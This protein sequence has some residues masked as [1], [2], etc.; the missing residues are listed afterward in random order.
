MQTRLQPEVRKE[1]I[2][3]AALRVFAEKGFAEASNRDIAKAAGVRSP[4]LIYHYFPSKMDLLR[5]IVES[6][7][8]LNDILSDVEWLLQQPP[9]VTLPRVGQLYVSLYQNPEA[10]LL[11]KVV[12][13]EAL[14]NKEFAEA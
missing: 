3:E 14:R 13:G 4:G 10:A 5:E 2:M 6:R 11:L 12:L 1:Q 9:E 8:H 7:G